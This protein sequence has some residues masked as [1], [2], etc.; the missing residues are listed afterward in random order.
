MNIGIL[1]FTGPTV[2]KNRRRICPINDDL[3]LAYTL[4]T[5]LNRLCARLACLA[6]GR[7]SCHHD[8]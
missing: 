3:A 6:T 1:G 4:G 8:A 2:K 5:P 7:R